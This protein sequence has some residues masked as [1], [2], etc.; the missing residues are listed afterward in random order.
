MNQRF[1]SLDAFR[2][3]AAL[4]VVVHH[5]KFIGTASDLVFFKEGAIFVEFFF[6]LSGFVLAHGYGFKKDL[7]FLVFM[8][9]RFFR[10]YP[11]HLFMFA[12]FLLLEFGKLAAYKY[13]GFTFSFTPFTG[14]NAPS[15][16]IPNLLLIQSWVPFAEHFS[17]NSPSWSISI[18]IYLYVL[19]FLSVVVFSKF[20]KYIWILTPVIVFYLIISESEILLDPV[21]RGLSGFF[22]GASTYLLYKKIHNIRTTRLLASIIE[23][24]VVACIIVLVQSKFE[25]RGIITTILFCIT[26]LVFS[27]ESG[28]VSNFLKLK[29][30]Q[31]AGKLSYSIYMIHSAIL[32]LITSSMMILQKIT[33]M[34]LAPMLRGGRHVTSGNEV[35]NNFLVVLVLAF[36]IL[37]SKLTYKHIELKWQ[38]KGKAITA[39]QMAI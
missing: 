19:L 38:K 22:G 39:K 4:I 23:V 14:R 35:I 26:I 27:F 18:E 11:L 13:G 12:V 34:E 28:V 25:Y 7:N 3:I 33:G 15:E 2:G 24:S 6:V 17:F 16:I 20:K 5:M 32:F 31:E 9:A 8:R 36:V 29:P 37:V 10:L 30:F 21:L 1:E